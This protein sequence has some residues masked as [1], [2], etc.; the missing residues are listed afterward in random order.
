MVQVST[1]VENP[2]FSSVTVS[3]AVNN[4][5][6][7][8]ADFKAVM[9]PTV[10]S[11]DDKTVLFLTGGHKLT[12]P[13][14]SANIKGFRGYFQL[15][16]AAVEANSFEMNFEG[17]VTGITSVQDSGFRVQGSNAVYDLQG[18]RVAQPAKGLYIVNGKKVIVK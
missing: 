9:A 16:G 17:D 7:T 2:V 13:N 4:T 12:W 14:A 1:D 18:R 11:K 10:L 8:H 3:N 6:T 15:K 5:V